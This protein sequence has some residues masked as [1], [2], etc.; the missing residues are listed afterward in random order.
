MKITLLVIGKTDEQYLETGIAKYLGRLEHYVPFELKIIPD[1]KN[2][3]TLSEAQQKKMEGELLLSQFQSGD[4]VVL[5][6]ENGKTFS[7]RNFSKWIESQMNT[8]CK[9]LVFVIGGP[10]GFSQE[11][12]EKANSKISLSEMTFSHQMVRLI[13]VEQLYRAFTIMKGEAY[14]HD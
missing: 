12:Y 11:V 5:L 9:R 3:K 1:I 4:V 8:G 2:R 10:Y 13:F 6:D 7:S 14:H